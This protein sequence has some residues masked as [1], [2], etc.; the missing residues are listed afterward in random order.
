VS[1]KVGIFVLII[2]AIAL[3]GA[4][5]FLSVPERCACRIS[6]ARLPP[7]Q[8]DVIDNSIEDASSI[9]FTIGL[10]GPDDIEQLR[11]CYPLKPKRGRLWES[12][13]LSDKGCEYEN[14]YHVEIEGTRKTSTE[15]VVSF[16]LTEAESISTGATQ[17]DS[18]RKASGLAYFDRRK[19]IC[20]LSLSGWND[21][22]LTGEAKCDSPV[23]YV[24]LWSHFPQTARLFYTRAYYWLHGKHS[25]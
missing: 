17:A 16:E 7:L 24:N 2:G 23:L 19:D 21:A 3:Y 5:Y 18:K 8:L 13:G 4:Y 22:T 20:Q 6:T 11:L 9:V 10:G 15:A 1:N 12:A 14:W 25:E